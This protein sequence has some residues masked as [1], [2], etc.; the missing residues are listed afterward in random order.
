MH[1]HR[2]R[3]CTLLMFTAHAFKWNWF[4]VSSIICF[5]C[6]SMSV[7]ESALRNCTYAQSITRVLHIVCLRRRVATENFQFRKPTQKWK[8]MK[9]TEREKEAMCVCLCQCVSF[10]SEERKNKI[11]HIGSRETKHYWCIGWRAHRPSVRHL[12]NLRS[13]LRLQCVPCIRSGRVYLRCN[14]VCSRFFF[15]LKEIRDTQRHTV[16]WVSSLV[17]YSHALGR[18]SANIL[19]M[20][21][22]TSEWARSRKRVR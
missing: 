8:Y 18:V 2:K 7:N 13:V 12:L 16:F 9:R 4:E 1:A 22:S 14:D 3:F 5:L 11:L 15:S 10:H 17:F 20:L 19:A 6:W 21:G